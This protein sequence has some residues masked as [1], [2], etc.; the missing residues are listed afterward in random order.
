[1]LEKTG[2]TG[3][4]DERADKSTVKN[5]LLGRRGARRGKLRSFADKMQIPLLE[6][7]K[8]KKIKR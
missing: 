4:W 6:E 2:R 3:D 7:S 1:V 5:T 8:K